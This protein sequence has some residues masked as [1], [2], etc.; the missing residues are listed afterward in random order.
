MSSK[1]IIYGR[2]DGLNEYVLANRSNKYAGNEMKHRNEN[3]ISMYIRQF[4]VKRVDKYPVKLKIV[5]YEANKKR[6]IDNITFATKFIQDALVKS[7]IL[8]NDNQ[9]CV[10]EVEHH[11]CVD[12]DNARIEVEIIEE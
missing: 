1:F 7:G 2:L 8:K 12:K 3:L 10:N 6:D 11:V 9:S 4:K 5:W